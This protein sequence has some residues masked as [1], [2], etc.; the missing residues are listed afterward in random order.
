MVKLACAGLVALQLLIIVTGNEGTATFFGDAASETYIKQQINAAWAQVG[1]TIE[2]QLQKIGQLL[3]IQ[4]H[5]GVT[6]RA[7]NS[8]AGRLPYCVA[9][10]VSGN[11]F[12]ISM[13]S[14]VMSMRSDT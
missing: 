1:V 6:S 5:T 9:S 8:A 7:G 2:F 12:S 14:E 4:T 10:L 13:V 3:Q 11:C